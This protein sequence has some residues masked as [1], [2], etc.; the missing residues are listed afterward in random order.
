M[1]KDSIQTRKRRCTKKQLGSHHYPQQRYQQQQF[2][3]FR[4]NLTGCSAHL[5]CTKRHNRPASNLNKSTVPP[6]GKNYQPALNY[7]PLNG[8]E[9][10]LSLCR[11]LQSFTK[12]ITD[13]I[14]HPAYINTL[15]SDRSL[16]YAKICE[17]AHFSSS[18]SNAASDTCQPFQQSKINQ[19]DQME[20]NGFSPF[21]SE[22]S[23]I[24]W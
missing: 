20:L 24:S 5:N 4:S 15:I 17:I 9:W 7:N 14:P 23:N 16:N 18:W 1:R 3:G 10:M 22:R 8:M 6:I 19:F 13:N 12:I 11:D 21:L 2:Y